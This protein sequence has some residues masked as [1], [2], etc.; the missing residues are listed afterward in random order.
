MGL[1]AGCRAYFVNA[2]ATACAAMTL[3]ELNVPAS[4]NGTFDHIH[5]FVSMASD[6]DEQFPIIKSHVAPKGRLWVSW[7]KGRQNGTDLNIREVIRI[8]YLHGMVESTTLSVS[9]VWSAIKFTFPIPGK[10]YSNSYGKLPDL[11]YDTTSRGV[12]E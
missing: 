10:R 9:D 4:L 7:P 11:D 2:P 1:K 12:S 3:P 5:L 8:G 6:L